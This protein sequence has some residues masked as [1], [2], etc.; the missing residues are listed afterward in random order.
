MKLVK[1]SLVAALLVGSSAY[2]MENIKVSGDARLY[3]ETV[4][5]DTANTDTFGKDSSNGQVALNL[6]MTGDIMEGISF[7]T[8]LAVT[9]T[10]G[11]EQNLVGGTWAGPV[12]N[13]GLGYDTTSGAGGNVAG[14]TANQW[15]LSEA[16]IAATVGNSTAKIGRQY[17]DTPLAF[18]ETWNIVS[19][20]FTAAVLLNQDIPN[21][22]LVG[23]YVG[24]SNGSFNTVATADTATSPFSSYMTN[25]KTVG[26]GNVTVGGD[27]AYAAG[28]INNSFAPLTVQAWY[29]DVMNV[30]TATWLQADLN[31]DGVLAGAQYANMDVSSAI[32][33]TAN[34]SEATA[35]MLGYEVK[36]TVTVK[37]AYSQSS[38]VGVLNIQNT[39]TGNQSKLYTETWWNYGYIG[40]PGTTGLMASATAPLA[41][42][43]EVFA[44]YND[45]ALKA[46]GM[47]QDAIQEAT[48]GANATVGP[49][50]ASLVYIHTRVDVSDNYTGTS[51]LAGTADYTESRVQAYLTLNF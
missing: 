19:N 2:A 21:T 31:M 40:L 23:A 1:M 51:Y 14:N 34:N 25:N 41:E 42:N 49:L 44:Q 22:T 3:Y 10:L 26:L 46:K 50:D 39:A 38:D 36:D 11:L 6:G 47:N 18:S 37:V 20:S 48:L 16:Y 29:Y 13:A 5:N 45:M 4:G 9:D 27:G 12:A 28:A 33:A 43:I 32:S 17:L 35:I 8:S 30:A 24:Q 15:W 7:G